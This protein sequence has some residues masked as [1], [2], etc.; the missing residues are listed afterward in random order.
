MKKLY[1][2]NLSFKATDEEVAALFS[3]INLHPDSLSL[4]RDR[5]TGQP[6]SQAEAAGRMFSATS[7]TLPNSTL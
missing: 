2:G 4:L 7:N 3:E 1:V 6:G 5:F